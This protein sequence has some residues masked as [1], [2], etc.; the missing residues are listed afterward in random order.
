MSTTISN[1]NL[2]QVSQAASGANINSS[3]A[4]AEA[5]PAHS[6]AGTGATDQ[7]FLTQSV[8]ALQQTSYD[9]APVNTDRVLQLQKAIDSG[10]YI[11]QP[12][13]IAEKMVVLDAQLPT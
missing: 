9:Q 1:S 5:Q 6:S 3:A 11:V 13:A 8:A 12:R 4:P 2:V 10:T 7:V